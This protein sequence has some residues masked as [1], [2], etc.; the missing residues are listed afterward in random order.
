VD[1]PH[2]S[3]SVLLVDGRRHDPAHAR[4]RGRSGHPAELDDLAREADDDV[5]R[6][7][8]LQARLSHKSPT[9]TCAPPTI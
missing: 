8:S 5:G 3:P 2:V 9:T 7:C 6:D 1:L 4:V